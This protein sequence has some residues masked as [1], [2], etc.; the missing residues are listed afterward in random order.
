MKL[1]DTVVL[2]YWTIQDGNA[3]LEFTFVVSHDDVE[4]L[5][6]SYGV[7]SLEYDKYTSIPAMIQCI[8]DA[9]HAMEIKRKSKRR[10]ARESV[11]AEASNCE[12][13]T[14]SKEF[15]EIKLL[16]EDKD[17]LTI[18]EFIERH[19]T[20][21]LTHKSPVPHRRSEHYRHYKSGKVVPIKSSIVN[22]NKG[23]VKYKVGDFSETNLF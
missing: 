22:G 17:S 16:S 15:I 23:L 10:N 9:Y 3:L 8:I 12:T 11:V 21:H 13:I 18:N 1:E 4:L 14:N 6:S 7:S 20:K 5:N 2:C 19:G